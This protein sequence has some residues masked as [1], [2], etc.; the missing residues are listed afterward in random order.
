M[1]AQGLTP[2]PG[3]E[4]PWGSKKAFIGEV[5]GPTLYAAG[6][7]TINASQLGWGGFDMA[8]VCGLSV[9]GVYYGYVQPL[10]IK[11]TPSLPQSAVSSFKLM[12]RV[13]ATGA[14]AGAIDLSA[15]VMRF[16]AI[17]V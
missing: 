11:T 3:Y 4:Q 17:G 6:G 16:F 13:L 15:E 5:F 10:P 1:A 14:E 2:L 12:W 8:M 7:Q 9:S